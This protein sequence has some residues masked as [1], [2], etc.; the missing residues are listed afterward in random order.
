MVRWGQ[1]NDN[2]VGE[3]AIFSAGFG[4]VLLCLGIWATFLGV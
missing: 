4:V 2:I 1:K 3:V